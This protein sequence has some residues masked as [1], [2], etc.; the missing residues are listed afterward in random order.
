MNKAIM[1]IFGFMAAITLF[2]ALF[3]GAPH[4]VAITVVSGIVAFM[5]F[6]AD[7]QEKENNKNSGV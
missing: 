7:R 1:Y 2:A 6:I 4:Q 5:G 3:L